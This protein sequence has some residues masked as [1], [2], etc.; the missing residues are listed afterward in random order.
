MTVVLM[1]II[2]LIGVAFF[3][4]MKMFGGSREVMNAVDAG[5]LNVCKQAIVN[6]NVPAATVATITTGAGT[7]NQTQ[8]LTA[9]QQLLDTKNGGGTAKAGVADLLTYNRL[10]S[11]VLLAGLNAEAD[12]GAN[13]VADAQTALQLLQSPTGSIG[14]LLQQKLSNTAWM[15][16]PFDAVAQSN[17]VRMAQQTGIAIWQNGSVGYVGQGQPQNSD[18]SN[19]TINA[20]GVTTATLMPYTDYQQGTQQGWPAGAADYTGNFL[21]GY[22]PITLGQ[23]G[24]STYIGTIYGV[25]VQPGM[26]PHLISQTI[27]GPSANSPGGKTAAVPPN[28]FGLS[29]NV[30]EQKT[31]IPLGSWS[32][33]IVGAGSTQYPLSMP[34]GYLVIDNSGTGI[35]NSGAVISGTFP[36]L[37]NVTGQELSTGIEAVSLPHGLALFSDN[38]ALEQWENY[39]AA[40]AKNPKNPPPQPSLNGLFDQNGQPATAKEAAQ[41]NVPP[42]SN[43]VCTDYNSQGPGANSLCQ[44]L[45]DNPVGSLGLGAFDTAYFGPSTTYGVAGVASDLTA[46]E[47][48][49]MDFAAVYA[50]AYTPQGAHGPNWTNTSTFTLPSPPV[51]T[52][53][54]MFNPSYNAMLGASLPWYSTNLWGPNYISTLTNAQEVSVLDAATV[55]SDPNHTGVVTTTGSLLQL[56]QQNTTGIPSASGNVAGTSTPASSGVPYT[57]NGVS[58]GSPPPAGQQ[59]ADEITRLVTNRIHQIKPTASAQE[60][61]TVLNTP[62]KLGSIYYVYMDK[63]GNIVMNT[64]AP[65]QVFTQPGTGTQYVPPISGTGYLGP[66]GTAV[67]FTTKFFLLTDQSPYGTMVNPQYDF[68]CDNYL[69]TQETIPYASITGQHNIIYTP[70]TGAYN[71]L[72]VIQLQDETYGDTGYFYSR[73]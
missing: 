53:M 72:G 21:S 22:Q 54:R 43:A 52:G 15:Q 48:A 39:D 10:V 36:N 46:D 12:G 40:M 42:S 50:S 24:S 3:F 58:I 67:T 35:A 28:A 65:H 8:I 16:T 26:Q 62:L 11:Q 44:G 59:P 17:S 38:G 31:N 49:A 32:A 1:F 33:G 37:N 68:G 56:V 55:Y 47:F 51:I 45:L 6:P 71:N 61:S 66:D 60:I 2:V 27:F 70:S 5:T 7:A 20:S 14:Q 30:T 19:I 29:A 63:N 25:P 9:L 34:N 13:A 4:V 18:S 73:N 57:R 23:T 41:A 69:F 64:R